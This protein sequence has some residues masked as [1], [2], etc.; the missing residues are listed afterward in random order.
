MSLDFV[1]CEID[2]DSSVAEEMF[3]VCSIHIPV[4]TPVIDVDFTSA[5]DKLMILCED[6]NVSIFNLN[7]NVF[8]SV[9]A[10]SSSVRI[11]C[12]PLDAL[13][14]VADHHAQV[15]MYDYTLKVIP[16]NYEAINCQ[17]DLVDSLQ[18]ICFVNDYLISLR[19]SSVMADLEPQSISS[20]LSLIILPSG[21]NMQTL[22]HEYLKNDM[23]N[24][25]VD[26]LLTLNWNF[27]AYL[28]YSCLNFI[29]NFLLKLPFDENKESQILSTLGA[30]FHAK[31]PIN[32]SIEKEY[33]FGMH[34][35][36]KRFFYHLVRHQSLEKA[37]LLAVDLKSKQLFSLLQKIGEETGDVKLSKRSAEYIEDISRREE[38]RRSHRERVKE[39]KLASA[40]DSGHHGVQFTKTSQSN[41]SPVSSLHH[42]SRD[43][44][45]IEE[46]D[47][48]DVTDVAPSRRRPVPV[49]RRSISTP[50]LPPGQ[51]LLMDTIIHYDDGTTI[52]RTSV[53][54]A[55]N[56]RNTPPLRP[57][58][59]P[60]IL[61]R[62]LQNHTG[63]PPALPPRVK[64]SPPTVTEKKEAVSKLANLSIPDDVSNGDSKEPPPL[65]PKNFNN[66]NNHDSL[67]KLIPSVLTP[68]SSMI[69]TLKSAVNRQTNSVTPSSSSSVPR[70][71]D[72]LIR[73][74][75][76]PSFHDP[77]K[78][79]Q[80]KNKPRIE[81]IH[82]GI[83]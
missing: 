19:Y 25:A 21:L 53:S 20:E 10:A 66:N 50:P 37:F 81:C 41:S 2:H 32:L 69:R 83:V 14:I 35:L 47:G 18:S 62:H 70:L 30:Y 48:F 42:H 78:S 79:D 82:F 29:L 40:V 44:T 7:E 71:G 46:N 55:S 22:I 39:T 43:S 59:P 33:K 17:F 67:E 65:P 75:P 8:Y 9:Q 27:D 64:T 52:E 4:L 56:P 38:K 24:E 77:S 1:I 57:Q 12:S 36:T 6:G 16:S 45:I 26:N 60:P 15:T 34:L 72:D 76:N 51:T 61:N 49:P 5:Q 63:P 28:T 74:P 23:T 68:K 13:F 58:N 3:K 11:M 80:N 73:D 54:V 31:Q